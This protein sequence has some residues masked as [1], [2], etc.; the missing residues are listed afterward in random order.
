VS[1]FK[2]YQ[3]DKNGLAIE[4]SAEEQAEIM[5]Q[6]AQEEAAIE[7]ESRFRKV[8]QQAKASSSQGN[9][10]QNPKDPGPVPSY[11]ASPAQVRRELGAVDPQAQQAKAL[12][13]ARKA[14]YERSQSLSK[15][16][17]VASQGIPVV[18]PAKRTP[19]TTPF[20]TPEPRR[21]D[22]SGKTEKVLNAV[23]GFK[24]QFQ[25]TDAYL[26]DGK[27]VNIH[28]ALHLATDRVI[29]A[30]NARQIGGVRKFFSKLR[31]IGKLFKRSPEKQKK[32]NENYNKALGGLKALTSSIQETY[33]DT[34]KAKELE[35]PALDL[36]NVTTE[37]IGKVS[38]QSKALKEDQKL[39]K[40]LISLK[41]K[42]LH[43]LE[44]P[45]EKLTS[46]TQSFQEN[47]EQKVQK[48]ERLM[49]GAPP[50]TLDEVRQLRAQVQAEQDKIKRGLDPERGTG[51]IKTL[52]EETKHHH[53]DA[54]SLK[55][56]YDDKSSKFVSQSTIHKEGVQSVVEVKQNVD[57][58]V[59]RMFEKTEKLEGFTGRKVDA[60]QE[61]LEDLSQKLDQIESRLTKEA[62]ARAQSE[63]AA[64]AAAEA[65]AE[66]DKKI[67][68]TMEA[69]DGGKSAPKATTDL[70]NS[71]SSS[72]KPGLPSPSSSSLMGSGNPPGA[73]RP[74]PYADPSKSKG[75]SGPSAG[76]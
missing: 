58:Q 62:A 52:I 59:G 37:V 23:A 54:L 34:S 63:A 31:G 39:Q 21:V 10:P 56:D 7:L 13:D 49:K 46:L 76:D 35:K 43:R 64:K 12:S 26:K 27:T 72:T 29:E 38:G 33:K 24:S 11:V 16:P 44:G 66:Q 75:S 69:L 60:L 73:A 51:S 74:D 61:K 47:F 18:T 1:D 15:S 55:T 8:E 25:N 6:K 41:E 57:S 30:D 45:R 36:N 40:D 9:N 67:Y 14:A 50:E 5:V 3:F 71:S 4:G 2:G 22:S 48:I 32:L 70:S 68:P 17:G 65:R 42:T 19:A 20:I 28:Q 53:K